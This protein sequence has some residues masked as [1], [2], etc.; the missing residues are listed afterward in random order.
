[1]KRVSY[2]ALVVCASGANEEEEDR[3]QH[4]S[5][6]ETGKTAFGIRDGPSRIQPNG[7]GRVIALAMPW[8]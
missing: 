8:A 7:T 2:S 4:A 5:K 1:M 6:L 3:A